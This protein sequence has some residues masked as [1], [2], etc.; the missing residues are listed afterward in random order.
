L[1]CLALS[2]ILSQKRTVSTP[3]PQINGLVFIFEPLSKGINSSFCVFLFVSSVA[4]AQNSLP[5]NPLYP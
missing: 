4:L 5:G 1:G 2:H 3:Q